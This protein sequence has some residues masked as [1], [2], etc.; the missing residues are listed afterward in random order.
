MACLKRDNNYN[1]AQMKGNNRMNNIHKRHS[2]TWIES[3]QG[4]CVTHI[5]TSYITNDKKIYAANVQFHF[6]TSAICKRYV[7][8]VYVCHV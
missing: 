6:L 2:L 8:I 1:K 4:I 7:N 3:Y 5:I